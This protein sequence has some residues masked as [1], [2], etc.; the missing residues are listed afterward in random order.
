MGGDG[1]KVKTVLINPETGKSSSSVLP[2]EFENGV[3][4]DW[5]AYIDAKFAET[6]PTR[7]TVKGENYTLTLTRYPDGFQSGRGTVRNA[8]N[9]TGVLV[10]LPDG[11]AFKPIVEDEDKYYVGGNSAQAEVGGAVDS[12]KMIAQTETTF[13]V[14][15]V[16]LEAELEQGYTDE[17]F[18]IFVYGDWK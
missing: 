18:T 5:K 12:L 13:T 2:S 16:H 3:G 6:Q 4:T 15:A 8:G 9:D 14:Q 1:M 11:Y 17:L 10:T 7:A